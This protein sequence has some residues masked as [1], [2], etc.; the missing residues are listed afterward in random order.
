MSRVCDVCGVVVSNLGRHKRRGR[1][2]NLFALRK[3]RKLRKQHLNQSK[4]R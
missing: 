4:H 2:E 3:E 1:C